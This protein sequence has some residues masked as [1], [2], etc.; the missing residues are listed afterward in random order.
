MSLLKLIF[1]FLA[2]YF[3]LRFI[4]NIVLPVSKAATQ[5][6]NKMNE[7]QN[8]QSAASHS[9]PSSAATTNHS[10]VEGEYIDFE[11]IKNKE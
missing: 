4:F 5:I 8:R 7:M 11:E 9:Q 10:E 3:L 1:T 2:I 6:K